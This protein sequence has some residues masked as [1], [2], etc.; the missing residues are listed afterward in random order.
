HV[1]AS[2]NYL[3]DQLVVR[4]P[5]RDAVQRRASVAT[6]PSKG[7]AVAALFDLKNERALPLKRGRAKEHSL[8]H[9]IA[10]PSVHVRAPR[11]ELSHMRKR[12]EDDRD[13]QHSQNGNRPPPPALFSF[14]GEKRKK[15]QPDDHHNRTN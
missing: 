5:H 8:R 13:Q 9:W 10:A 7:V 4:E 11:R 14:A 12:S 3:S 1:A 2:L 6:G 15:E